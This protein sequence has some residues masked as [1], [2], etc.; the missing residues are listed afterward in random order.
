MINLIPPSAKKRVVIEYWVR[1]ISLWGFLGGSALLLMSTLF[2][3]LNIYVTNQ[4]SYLA[5]VLES[6][7]IEQNNH[8]QNSAVLVQANKQA[9]FLLEDHREY[10]LHVLLPIL[11]GIA[12]GKVLLKSVSLNQAKTPVLM[13][14]GTAITR[15]SLVDFRDELEGQ[16]DFLIV[17]LPISN[18]IADSDVNFTIRINLATSTAAI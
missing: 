6:N 8:Q 3:P 16:S 12:D 18:L 15:Q 13:L 9:K 17:D 14:G 11:Q 1:T 10:A 7:K 5:T 2:V 4:E